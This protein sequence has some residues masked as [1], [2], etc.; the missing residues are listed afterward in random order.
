M[1]P[2]TPPFKLESGVVAHMNSSWC[3]RV[4]R[5]DLVTFQVDGT[6]GSAVAGLTKCWTQHRVNTPRPVWNPGR[7]SDD[8]FPVAMGRSAGEHRL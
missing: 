8:E 2:P 5:D 7:S 1:T 6:H 3:V 4:R